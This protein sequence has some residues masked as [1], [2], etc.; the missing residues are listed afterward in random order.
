MLDLGC[1][2]LRSYEVLVYFS[3]K[4]LCMLPPE[5]IFASRDASRSYYWPSFTFPLH[6]VSLNFLSHIYR[7]MTW[8]SVI[9]PLIVFLYHCSVLSCYCLVD[10]CCGCH[11]LDVM[12]FVAFLGL[13][14]FN[15]DWLCYIESLH[16]N[17]TAFPLPKWK[18]WNLGFLFTPD[19]LVM[20]WGGCS[21]CC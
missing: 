13:L 4:C 15:F 21:F 7:L 11:S 16:L 6:L 12:C 10:I 19:L 14:C 3:S 5:G 2:H 17:V 18:E 1:T 8:T 9:W 20:E